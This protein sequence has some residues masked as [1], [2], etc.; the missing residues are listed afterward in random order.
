MTSSDLTLEHVR[1]TALRRIEECRLAG[2]DTRHNRSSNLQAVQ[3]VVDGDS[4]Y[5]WD[6]SGLEK[7]SFDETLDAIATIT[8]C[9][10]DPNVTAGGGY[11][12]PNATLKALE[13]ASGKIAAVAKGGGKFLLG[14]GHPGSLI[15]FYIELARLIREWGGEVRQPARGESVPPNQE[16]GYVDGVAVA[17]D[18]ASLMHTHGHRAMDAM[19]E[20]AA[21]VDLV[22]ADHGYAGAAINAGIPVI[23]VMD[24][25]DPALALAHRIGAD[26]LI[27]P[28]DDNRPLGAYLP[29]IETIREFGEFFEPEI[30]L[31]STTD[32][33]P[34]SEALTGNRL[35]KAEVAVDRRYPVQDGLD[36]LVQGFLESFRDQLVQ[37]GV[38]SD[39]RAEVEADPLRDIVLYARV[40]DAVHRGVERLARSAQSGI[41][42]R[43]ICEYLD[44]H[45]RRGDRGETKGQ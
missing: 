6:I 45:A 35:K 34:R 29:V 39:D 20:Q 7:F 2:Q 27:I 22:I 36:H 14:T 3:N 43:L 13:S 26:V 24:T 18:R 32:P 5:T 21:G 42:Q 16:L 9:S 38:E 33:A 17:T 19:I 31:R 41:D 10:H 23:A 25:N 30:G 44:H 40:H 37:S 8:G 1:E 28:M 12:S 15:V 11:I 4:H